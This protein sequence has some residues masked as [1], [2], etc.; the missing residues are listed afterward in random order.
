[1][2]KWLAGQLKKPKITEVLKDRVTGL[3]CE[4]D[5]AGFNLN[6]RV[7]GEYA[8]KVM[9]MHRAIVLKELKKGYFEQAGVELRD[10]SF[11]IFN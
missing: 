4:G 9:E 11:S 1:M 8:R 7:N 3:S 2:L 10:I 6:I 5:E